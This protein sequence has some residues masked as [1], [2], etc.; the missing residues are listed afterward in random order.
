MLERLTPA[1]R[2][3]ALLV[4]AA[5]VLWFGW[6]VRSVL[7]P[8][9]LGY[10]LAFVLHP[11]VLRLERRGWTR[12]RAVN[13]IY[14]VSLALV[15]ALSLAV[16]SQARSLYHEVVV[17]GRVPARIESALERGL[18]GLTARVETWTGEG[19]E[20]P[21]AE[22]EVVPPPPSAAPEEE[23]AP[24]EGGLG[25][26]ARDA[27]G[28]L[29]EEEQLAAR[30]GRA[31]LAAA[32]GVGR[33]VLHFFGSLIG[34]LTLV[35]L[36]PMY[37]YFL[38]FELERIHAFVRRYLP[39]R[40][41][42]RLAR[43]AGEIGAVLE[44][45]FRGRLAVCFFKGLFLTVGLWIADVDY[46]FLLGMGS[47]FLSLIPFIGPFLGLVAAFLLGLLE[48]SLLASGVRVAI[49]FGLGEVLEG[50]VLIPYVLGDSLGLHPVVVLASITIGAAA[51]GMF[52][53]LIALPLAAAVVIVAR[54]LVLPALGAWADGR[55]S[56]AVTPPPE[57]RAGG[58]T[59]A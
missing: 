45:F 41:R 48:H 40:D 54:E 50:Y 23:V 9:L 19:D 11:M 5:L 33:T 8:I 12:R 6:S 52:G 7:N 20:A 32:G 37:T 22:A 25:R 29:R 31:G 35:V 38:L 13:V 1:R 10:L 46:A 26:L 30:A 59:P 43:V 15:G 51:L 34:F 28:V 58:G 44:S 16:A 3:V 57:P 18:E 42:E 21:P 53:A 56:P 24:P 49:V 4:L 17:E 47:G 14:A 36:L 55:A 27:V 2:N 39:V